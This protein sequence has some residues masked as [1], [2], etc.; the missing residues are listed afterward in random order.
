MSGH[1]VRNIGLRVVV[2]LAGLVLVTGMVV[3][4][5]VPLSSRSSGARAA[6]GDV[7]EVEV[8]ADRTAPLFD[9]AVLVPGRPS[10]SCLTVRTEGI[11]D[12]DP[13]TV[14]IESAAAGPALASATWVTVEHGRSTAAE[15]CDGFTPVGVVAADTLAALLADHGGPGGAPLPS[16]DPRPGIAETTFRITLLLDVDA[17]PSVAGAAVEGLDLRWRTAVAEPSEEPL[18]TQALLVLGG[19]AEHSVVPL[20]ALLSIGLVFLGVQDRIDRRDPKLAAA[21]VVRGHI[22]FPPPPDRDRDRT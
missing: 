6:L 21:P 3:R 4:L 10:S 19:V 17:P 5:S 8:H 16:V 20:M 13:L 11:G 14:E 1:R 2:A 9:R 15:G 12:P 22:E 7:A 18:A